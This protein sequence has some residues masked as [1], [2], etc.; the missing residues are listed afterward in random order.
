MLRSVLAPAHQ[1]GPIRFNVKINT[2]VRRKGN[3]R[4]NPAE[5]IIPPGFAQ[6]R[7]EHAIRRGVTG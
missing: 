7:Y 6:V 3:K 4:R 1:R 5:G 2:K